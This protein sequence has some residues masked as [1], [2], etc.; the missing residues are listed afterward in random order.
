MIVA[1]P[2]KYIDDIGEEITLI[3][4]DGGVLTMEIRGVKFFGYDFDGFEPIKG[5]SPKNLEKFTLYENRDLCNCMI[6]CD[7]PILVRKF[8]E[9]IIS[10]LSFTLDLGKPR[11][12]RGIDKEDL[13]LKLKYNNIEI[14]SSGKTGW[15][16]DELIDIKRKLPPNTYLLCCFTCAYSDYHPVGH[17]LFGNMM[18]FREIKDEYLAV[19]TKLD[20]LHIA[21]KMTENVQETYFCN[22]FM[23]RKPGTGYRG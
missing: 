21:A 23:K 17:G 10:T 16:E 9:N 5:T 15:F 14:I 7:I 20:F 18:C 2:T 6:E 8:T 12:P 1:Y 19:K 11:P 4:N 3:W 22:E 13:L